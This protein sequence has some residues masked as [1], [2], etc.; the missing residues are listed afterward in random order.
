MPHI[1]VP[2]EI[3]S[4]MYRLMHPVETIMVFLRMRYQPRYPQKMTVIS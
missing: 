2:R 4:I 3:S 1:F